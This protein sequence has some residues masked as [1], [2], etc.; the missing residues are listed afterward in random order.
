MF[1]IPLAIAALGSIMQADAQSD[2]GK[3]AK[4]I[5]EYNATVDESDALQLELDSLETVR[6]M[7]ADGK[8]TIGS[9]RASY[10][11]GGVMVDTGSPLEVMAETEGMLKLQQLDQTRQASLE[12]AKLKRS[13]QMSRFYGDTEMR[14]STIRAGASLLAGAGEA[15]KMYYNAKG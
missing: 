13:A 11:K 1:F 9:Q 8:K 3:T 5:G 10:A 4:R 6:R 14:A 7:R 12:S 2:A 15:T